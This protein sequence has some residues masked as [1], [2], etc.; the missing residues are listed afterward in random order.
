[1]LKFLKSAEFSDEVHVLEELESLARVIMVQQL[2]IPTMGLVK[3]NRNK[4]QN[5]S[6][7]R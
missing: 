2:S 5:L 4:H 1:M 3:K 7:G 6:F